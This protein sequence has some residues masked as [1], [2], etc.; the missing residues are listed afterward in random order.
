MNHT[1]WKAILRPVDVQEIDVTE[2]AELLAARDQNEQLCVWFKCDPNAPRTKRRIA[3]VGTGHRVPD[4]ARYVGTGLL[5][6]GA[7][8]FHVF[9]MDT[10]ENRQVV[11]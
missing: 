11:S 3:V 1:I 2:G 8:V 4:R 5:Q 6:G 10:G 7:L 9:E